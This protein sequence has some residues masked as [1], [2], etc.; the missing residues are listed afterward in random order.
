MAGAPFPSLTCPSAPAFWNRTGDFLDNVSGCDINGS[1]IDITP[2]ATGGGTI[3]TDG[4]RRRS[5]VHVTSVRVP[6]G[7][8]A[9][10]PGFRLRSHMT[11]YIN[12][13]AMPKNPLVIGGADETGG[14][15]AGSARVRRRLA[16]PL[17]DARDR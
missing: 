12:G 8:T 3:R 15:A 16:H 17:N 13:A 11:V 6:L 4:Q 1:V 7:C 14:G 2:N 5:V 10:R 9:C